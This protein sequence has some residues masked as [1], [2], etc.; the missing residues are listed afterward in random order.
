[1]IEWTVRRAI[2]PVGS[3]TEVAVSAGPKQ[4]VIL[5]TRGETSGAPHGAG[6]PSGT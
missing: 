1:M 3:Q 2:E 5:A 4:F 6:Q